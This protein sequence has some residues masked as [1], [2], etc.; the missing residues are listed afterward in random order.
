MADPELVASLASQLQEHGAIITDHTRDD[1]LP[2][3]SKATLADRYLFGEE[4]YQDRFATV[5]RT[6]AG[7]HARAERIYDAISRLWF[8]PATPILA[9]GGTGRGLPISCLTANMRVTTPLGLIEIC[10][11]R[12]GD[13]VLTH[14]GRFRPIVKTA[15]RLST[16]DLFQLTVEGALRPLEI[17]GNHPIL[18]DHGW[19]RVDKIDVDK[20]LS[21]IFK[22]Q[23]LA[24]A[25]I[26]ECKRIRGTTTVY[27]LQVEEDESFV[28]ENVVVHNC[29]LNEANDSMRSIADLWYENIWLASGGGGTGSY[30]GN[31]RGLGESIGKRG[32]S[33]GVVPF[34]KVVDSLTLAISQGS[35]R[36]GSAAIYLPVDHP[37]ILEFIDIRRPTGGDVNRRCLNLHHGVIVTDAFMMAVENGDAWHLRSPHTREIITTVSARDVWIRILT[38]RLE[39]GEPYI[40]YGDTVN[41]NRPPIPTALDLK[42]KTSNLCTAGDTKILTDK[43]YVEIQTLAGHDVTLW[44]GRE[45]S[46]S[47]VEKTS[48]HARMRKVEFSNSSAL[49]VTDD[50]KFYAV[51]N[52]MV[53][54]VR[55]KDLQQGDQLEAWTLPNRNGIDIATVVSNGTEFKDG[56]TYC[57]NEPIRHRIILDGVETGNCAEITLPTG[58]DHLNN[59]RTAVCCLSSLN[60]ETWDE[61]KDEPILIEDI[62]YFLDNVLSEFIETAP[63]DYAQAKYAAYRERSVGL[64]VMGFHSF[65]IKNNIPFGSAMTKVWNKRFFKHIRTQAD[66]ASVKIAHDLGPCPDAMDAGLMERFSHKLA[67]APTASISIICGA[68]SAGIEPIPAN[69]YPHKTL[70][71]SFTCRNKYLERELIEH[72]E[73]TPERW[74]DIAKHQGSVQHLDFL[75]DHTKEVFKTAFE[76]DQRWIVELAAD[77]Q[78]FICQAQSV[79]L[80]LPADVHKRDLHHIHYQA[81][82]KGLKSLYY[83][84]SRSVLSAGGAQVD[85]TRDR[86]D[87]EECLA[88]Q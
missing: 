54:E 71:G 81:W 17:T 67:I 4:S 74:E 77:R 19:T 20:Y 52:H 34:F 3:F 23:K 44:N 9:N 78:P 76:I 47:R 72:N 38:A 16:S 59:M 63:D 50:H 21:C 36:R 28:V 6:Y 41:K 37:E 80:F 5:A 83:C 70:S 64:G 53:V 58:L 88:C 61:W 10:K 24:Y 85:L 40:I 60:L 7:N 1:L 42:V 56:P 13:E 12:E 62:M 43:G 29:Y 86:V 18:T 79:N 22:D 57:A 51:R 8:M 68:T 66:A 48:D 2:D 39:Q 45:W 31:V 27:D 55:A 46:L 49:F 11:L 75:D 33:S 14:K 69:V 30:F 32:K 26:S 87:Y 82:R 15:T 25:R 84:R 73:N 65:L 35:M